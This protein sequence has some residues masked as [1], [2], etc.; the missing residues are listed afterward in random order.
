MLKYII[1]TQ[2]TYNQTNQ[3]QKVKT[4]MILWLLFRQLKE[5]F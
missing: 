5:V 1:E 4:K 3:L 2:L